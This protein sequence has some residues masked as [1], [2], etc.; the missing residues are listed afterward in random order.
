MVRG[1]TEPAADSLISRSAAEPGT[2]R[3]MKIRSVSYVLS[4][5]NA[6]ECPPGG[7]AEIA[8]SGRSNVGKSTLVNT[9]L[10]R[11]ALAKV[12][13]TPG[14]TQRLNYFLVNE[15]FHLVD[16]PGYGYAKAPESERRQW[17]G[18]MQQYLQ[19]RDQLVA[20]IQLIDCRHEPS[21]DDQEMVQWLRDENL[22]F[23]LVA[24]KLDKLRQSQRAPS[25]RTILRVLDLPPSQMLVPYSSE[26]GE[27]RAALLE[28]I[29]QMIET[30]HQA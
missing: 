21:K 6:R 20:M 9:L 11:R 16:L 27:G 29:G 2:L 8:L 12:S 5:G 22:P 13:S 4:A 7:M 18:M 23:V 1:T 28:W 30:V 26:T 14:K 24:T 25:L 17:R 19:K 10:G 3:G 15:R